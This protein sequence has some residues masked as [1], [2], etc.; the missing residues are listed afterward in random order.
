VITGRIR[1]FKSRNQ[2]LRAIRQQAKAEGVGNLIQNAKKYLD[3]VR[4]LKKKAGLEKPTIDFFQKLKKARLIDEQDL[5]T[6]SSIKAA[7]RLAKEQSK[8]NRKAAIKFSDDIVTL[9]IRQQKHKNLNIVRKKSQKLSKPIK[10][11]IDTKKIEKEISNN[12]GQAQVLLVKKAKPLIK[13][14]QKI[15]QKAK[16]APKKAIQKEVSI[17]ETRFKILAGFSKRL[18]LTRLFSRFSSILASLATVKTRTETKA[19]RKAVVKQKPKPKATQKIKVL[20]KEKQR[21]SEEIKQAQEQGV[22]QSQSISQAVGVLQSISQAINALQTQAISASRL[23]SINKLIR[24]AKQLK[25]PKIL[26]TW[27]SKIPRG[28]SPLV[29]PI[30]RIKGRNREIRLRTTPNRAL[31]YIIS[32]IDR[33][34]AR[35]FQLKII[36]IKK[37]KDIKKQSLKKFRLRK[38]KDARVLKFV[39]KSKY[40]I[41]TKGEKRGLK[42]AR[43]IKK[44]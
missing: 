32:K 25:I 23:K 7:A 43:L 22:S 10:K 40:A 39:E 42:I 30:V 20:Q 11:R 8:V 35:S 26:P 38:G 4:N 14:V 12:Q 44:R 13:K 19:K 31:R 17:L 28:Y 16:I 15:K 24:V 6:Y 3:S 34:T 21:L 5:G 1:Y 9:V 2:W 37:A 29:N 27:S 33:T 36:G 18:F 41:D